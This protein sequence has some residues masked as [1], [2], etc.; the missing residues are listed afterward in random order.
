MKPIFKILVI[1]ATLFLWS[2]MPKTIYD[3]FDPSAQLFSRAEKMFQEKSYDNALVLYNEYLDRFSDKPMAGAALMKMGAIHVALGNN[4]S[5]RNVYNRLITEYPESYFIP[6]ARI[7]IMVTYYN[8]GDYEKVIDQ[9]ADFLKHAVSESHIFRT[10]VLAGDAYLALGYP[11]DAVNYYATAYATAQDPGKK[12]IILKLKEAVRQLSDHDIAFLLKGRED[13]FPAGYLMFQLGIRRAGEEKY[14]EALRVLSEFIEKFPDHENVQPA[15]NLITE[16]NQKTIF[17][18]YTIGCLLPLSGPYR[19]YGNKALNGV[20]L[21]LNKFSSQNSSPYIKVIIKDTESDPVKT[22]RAVKELFN[23]KVAAIIGPVIMAEPAAQEAQDH[24]VP[25]ITLTQKGNITSIGDWVFRN[26]LTPVAQVKALVFFAVE[27]LNLNRFAILYPDENYGKTFMNLFWDEVIAFGGRVTGVESYNSAHTDFSD[28]IKKLVG[29]Y[30]EVPEHLN[31]TDPEPDDEK[32]ENAPI[33]EDPDTPPGDAR[34]YDENIIEEKQEKAE[35]IVDFDAVFIPDAPK[36]AGLIIPQLAFYD[37]NDTYLLGTNL[38]H[39]DSLIDM[40]RQYVQDAIIPDGFF[41]ESTSEEVKDFV[42]TFHNT[43]HRT[44]EFIEA[45]AYDTAMILFQTVSSP[46]IRFRSD[47]KNKLKT[48]NSYRGVTGLT[49]FDK[50]GEVR[51]KLYL[52]QIKGNGFVELK[53]H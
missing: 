17:S 25:I 3:R 11:K 33:G 36:K 22:V 5:A 45:V 29:L 10:S 21:A 16:I 49:S 4:D 24:G 41:P 13:R 23:E 18:R 12:V 9:A 40:A 2:C 20:E 47:L 51:K 48:L 30:Y 53:P 14:D 42:G 31:I 39:S 46:D 34:E 38:W 1:I 43:F 35:A 19:Y 52:L 8:Q 28:S 6:E 32:N 44:P 50:S 7:E 26:F 37:V 27:E 15:K